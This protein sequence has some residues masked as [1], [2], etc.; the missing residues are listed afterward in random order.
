MVLHGQ[1]P[2]F[3]KSE[4]GERKRHAADH[5]SHPIADCP[6]IYIGAHDSG[7]DRGAKQQQHQRGNQQKDRQAIVRPG[8]QTH[9]PGEPRDIG[10]TA[11]RGE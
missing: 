3:C 5:H 4:E 11:D 10:R 8:K 1:V 9:Q 2:Q 6:F 7:P